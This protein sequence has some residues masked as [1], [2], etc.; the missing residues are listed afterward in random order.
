MAAGIIDTGNAMPD[1]NMTECEAQA[2]PFMA[3]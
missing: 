2:R 3:G 1:V